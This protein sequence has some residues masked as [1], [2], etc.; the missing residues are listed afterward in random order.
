[1]STASGALIQASIVKAL[2][3]SKNF[4]ELLIYTYLEAKARD[5]EEKPV[6]SGVLP[7]SRY[8]VA[9]STKTKGRNYGRKNA[10][11]P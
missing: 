11:A 3:E 5:R 2:S 7:G 6:K 9:D 1:M 8:P 4:D 10:S